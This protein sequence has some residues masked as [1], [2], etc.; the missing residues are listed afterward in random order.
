LCPPKGNPTQSGTGSPFAGAENH[1][2]NRSATGTM[3][4]TKTIAGENQVNQYRI[5]W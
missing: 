4:S 1:T 5:L 3:C 2:T